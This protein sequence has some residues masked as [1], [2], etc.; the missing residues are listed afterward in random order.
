MP[1]RPGMTLRSRTLLRELMKGRH[2]T[3]TLAEQAGV[4]KQLVAYLTSGS[5]RSCSPKT[6]E[7]ICMA[8]GCEV[9]TLFSPP[10]SA[11]SSNN[12]EGEVLLSIAQVGDALGISRSH[13]YR[14]VPELISA[15]ELHTV[16]VALKGSTKTK[17][18]IPLWSVEDWIRKA[19]AQP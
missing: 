3:V 15:G 17:T 14:K 10:V 16:D 9:E 2:N 8:L 13:A 5:R 4:S 6:A 12:E 11:N 19:A 18:R 7:S 1:G